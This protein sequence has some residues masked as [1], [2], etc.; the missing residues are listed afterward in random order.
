V[1]TI[2]DISGPYRFFFF[3]FDC[4]E[5]EHVHVERDRQQCKFWL[6]PVAG[7]Q[8]WIPAPRTKQDTAFDY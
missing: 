2:R 8:Q 6:D 4:D 1:P 7:K 5:P 3:S